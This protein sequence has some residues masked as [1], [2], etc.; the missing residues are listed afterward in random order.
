MSCVL[1]KEILRK[2]WSSEN[3]EREWVD[4]GDSKPGRKVGVV[5][6]GRR[7]E[8]SVP[9]GYHGRGN[10][11]GYFYLIFAR[12]SRRCPRRRGESTGS[13]LSTIKSHS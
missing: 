9:I 5:A 12:P 10:D 4:V 1:E 11:R 13:L 7:K 8:E 2:E 6:F 3:D